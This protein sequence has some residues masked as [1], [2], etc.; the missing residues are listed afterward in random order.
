M[1]ECNNFSVKTENNTLYSS[2]NL[3]IF[4][5]IERGAF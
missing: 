5:L 1:S 3:N 2:N 4:N